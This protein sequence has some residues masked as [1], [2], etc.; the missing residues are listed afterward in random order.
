MGKNNS[1]EAA[2]FLSRP[3]FAAACRAA[4]PTPASGS[5]EGK[6]KKFQDIKSEADL[7]GPGAAPG[8][9]PTDSHNVI[10]LTMSRERPVERCPECGNVLKMDYVGPQEDPHAHD[11]HGHGDHGHAYEEPKTFADFVRPEYR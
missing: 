2:M 11:A 4:A 8:T 9:I 1:I 3:A 6:I 7:I 5:N 10:W